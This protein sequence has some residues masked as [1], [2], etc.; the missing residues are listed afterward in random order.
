MTSERA[1]AVARLPPL[2][3]NPFD[4]TLIARPD[5]E[6]ATFLTG[7]ATA[8]RHAGPVRSVG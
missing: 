7:A 2:C 6:G 1:V 3:K 4:S 8:V 5:V